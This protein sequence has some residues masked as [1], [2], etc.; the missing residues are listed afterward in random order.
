MREEVPGSLATGAH[1]VTSLRGLTD[2]LSKYSFGTK[3]KIK[4]RLCG[5]ITD[6]S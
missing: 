1:C 4:I 6:G 2:N 5:F 3:T